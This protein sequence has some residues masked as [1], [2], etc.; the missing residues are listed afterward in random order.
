MNRSDFT[1]LEPIFGMSVAQITANILVVNQT[2][3]AD[4]VSAFENIR[5]INRAQFG[6]S[7]SR[8]IALEK[9]QKAL[10]WFLDDDV[11]ITENSVNEIVSA[12]NKD[13]KSI[14]K[15]FRIAAMDGKPFRQ[16]PENLRRPKKP[17][18]LRG[19]CSIEMV[20]NREEVLK[21]NIQ[22]NEDLGLG[23]NLPIGEEFVFASQLLQ[24]DALITYE[25]AVI[26]KHPEIHS[27]SNKMMN[28]VLAARGK[29]Y[30]LV[31]PKTATI[32]IIKYVWSLA[33]EGH[34]SSVTQAVQ[35]YKL[36]KSTF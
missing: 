2:I 6:L 22:F 24:E 21:T 11:V 20:V 35:S 10:L 14:L 12:F 29:V 26:A 34:V 16:Y 17:I 15:I 13:S 28:D 8:N 33:R 36:L 19:L 1:F 4:L 31:Y 7:R 9:G 5:V 3:Q 32:Q 30:Q 25:K 23:T 27:A 18:Q